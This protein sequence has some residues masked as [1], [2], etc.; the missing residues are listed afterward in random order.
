MKIFNE[1]IYEDIHEDISEHIYEDKIFEINVQSLTL[2][3]KY[4]CFHCKSYDFT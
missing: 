1:D 3:F 4:Y 2:F